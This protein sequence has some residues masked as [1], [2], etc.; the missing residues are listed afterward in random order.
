M[1]DDEQTKGLAS[2]EIDEMWG[3]I[4]AHKDFYDK[5]MFSNLQL[6]VEAVLS[7]PHSNA[8]AE[9]IF[10][11]IT[12]AK[13]KERNWLSNDTVSAICVTRSSFQAEGINCTNFKIDP[14]HL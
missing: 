4:L 5:I 10:S 1:F 13:N 3:K 2:L 14:R 9:Q 11:I 12:D 6:L 8:E 7:L